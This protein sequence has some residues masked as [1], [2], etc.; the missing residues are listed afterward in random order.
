[1][2]LKVT[3]KLAQFKQVGLFHIASFNPCCIENGSGMTLKKKKFKKGKKYEGK[4]P[5][6]H[7]NI[8]KIKQFI[9]NQ[10][11]LKQMKEDKY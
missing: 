1:M 6:M 8:F 11:H 2:A 5:Y 3:A 10:F 4:L 7:L 9:E